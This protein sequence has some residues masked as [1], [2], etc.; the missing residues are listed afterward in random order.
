MLHMLQWLYMHVASVCSQ[1]FICF[2]DVCRKCVYL[3]VAYV[4]HIYVAKCFIWM[5][6]MFTM[7]FRCFL[8]VS[9][10]VSSVLYVFFCTLQV[11]YLDVLKVDRVLHI[12]YT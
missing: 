8:S 2:S 6:R 11:L 9:A 10:Y 5:L 7:V 1:Y 4:S 3:D 12:G